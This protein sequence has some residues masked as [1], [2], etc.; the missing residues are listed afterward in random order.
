MI[1]FAQVVA[2]STGSMSLVA[3]ALDRYLAVLNKSNAKLLRSKIFCFLGFFFIW[4]LGM[5]ISSPLLVSYDHIRIYVVPKER[6]E[7][8]YE[9]F[10][11]IAKVVSLPVRTTDGGFEFFIFY[12]F[13]G[14]E[15]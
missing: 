12:P 8:F 9:S 6:Q 15:G 4:A 10:L 2:V 5:A 14:R 1:P 7:D 13:T 11:C 3:I